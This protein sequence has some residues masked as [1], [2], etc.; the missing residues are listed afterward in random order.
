MN[1]VNQAQIPKAS[2][3]KR[4]LRSASV[5]EPP[6]RLELIMK[7][8]CMEVRDKIKRFGELSECNIIL[9]GPSGSGKSSLIATFN[10]SLN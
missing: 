4:P 6:S 5:K 1:Y 9:F 10:Q 3:M 8:S 2:I 7:Q